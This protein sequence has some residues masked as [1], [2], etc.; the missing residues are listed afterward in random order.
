MKLQDALDILDAKTEGYRVE[1][2][3]NLG[4]KLRLDYFPGDDELLLKS[5]AEAIDLA[6]D[7]SEK[8]GGLVRNVEVKWY[9]FNPSIRYGSHE[10]V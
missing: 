6:D 10:G 5:K 8:M 9:M 4:Y 3:W 1:F 7:F 2:T